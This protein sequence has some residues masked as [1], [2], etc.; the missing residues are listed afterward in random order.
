M[1]W[2]CIVL[3]FDMVAKVVKSDQSQSQFAVP[4]T[5]DRKTVKSI[6][7]SKA[8]HNRPMIPRG[9]KKPG[10]GSWQLEVTGVDVKMHLSGYCTWTLITILAIG[11][12]E[13]F[14]YE[15]FIPHANWLP[16][17]LKSPSLDIIT[18]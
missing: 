13:V 11:F 17:S 1:A 8:T 9:L 15:P 14:G 10:V 4:V 5:S 18:Y 6:L 3:G 2:I 7:T 16:F 12:R